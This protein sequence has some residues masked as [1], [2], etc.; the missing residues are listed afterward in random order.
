MS[1]HLKYLAE[2]VE[3]TY[4]RVLNS[5]APDS[6][7]EHTKYAELVTET[8]LRARGLHLPDE[9]RAHLHDL[10]VAAQAGSQTE[11]V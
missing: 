6:P 11:G 10:S 9:T 7:I 2:E 3:L 4:W 5:L 1:A 8:A